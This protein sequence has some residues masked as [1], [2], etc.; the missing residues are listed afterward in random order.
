MRQKFASIVDGQEP[1][2]V[3]LQVSGGATGQW[4]MK[5]LFDRYDQMYLVNG[6]K[7]FTRAHQI[8]VGHF[9]VFNY[10]REAMLTVS[11]FGDRLPSPLPF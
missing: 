8:K 3:L 2:Q 6:W 4:T 11:V 5:V 10:D 1:H 7:E 9:L